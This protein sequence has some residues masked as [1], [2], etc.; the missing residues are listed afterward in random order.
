MHDYNKD[1]S[2]IGTNSISSN[3]DSIPVKPILEQQTMYNN[4]IEM[5]YNFLPL[6]L[7]EFHNKV[8]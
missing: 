6:H 5:E 1:S 7:I 4:A 3:K 8:N 2:N